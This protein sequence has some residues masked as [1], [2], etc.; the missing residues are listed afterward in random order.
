MPKTNAT[1]RKRRKNNTVRCLHAVSFSKYSESTSHFLMCMFSIKNDAVN[2]HKNSKNMQPYFSSQL[3]ISYRT[4]LT[5]GHSQK[6]GVDSSTRTLYAVFFFSL[7]VSIL[8]NYCY[9]YH[10]LTQYTR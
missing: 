7:F 8:I 1:N 4:P 2:N 10:L 6:K 9:N 3:S 5:V